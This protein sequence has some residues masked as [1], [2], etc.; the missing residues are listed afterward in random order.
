M[1]LLAGIGRT[2]HSI[3]RCS[4][5]EQPSKFVHE[6][7]ISVY[8]MLLGPAFTLGKAENDMGR[9]HFGGESRVRAGTTG[10]QRGA[11]LDKRRING[12]E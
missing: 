6:E 4:L 11:F 8:V 3:V 7:S 9:G 1:T 10:G 5:D 2:P 12:P